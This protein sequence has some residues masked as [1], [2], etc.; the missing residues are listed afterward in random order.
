M[1]KITP[2]ILL[3]LLLLVS[4]GVSVAQ[5]DSTASQFNSNVTIFYVTCE[6]QGVVNLTGTMEPNFDVYYQLFSGAGGTGTALTGLRQVSVDGTYA[7]SEVTAYTGGTVPAGSTGSIKVY[8]A[9]ETTP[10]TPSGDTFTVDDIQDG[11]NNPQNAVTTSSDAGAGSTSSSSTSGGIRIRSP[12]GGY[13]NSSV[14]VTPEPPVVIGARQFVNPERS[15]TP[16]IIFAECDNFL[17]AA[18]PG[19]VYDNDN[20]VI[21]WSWYAKTSAQVQDHLAK[22][23]YSVR[24][25]S[26]PLVD[27]GTSEIEQ[28]G[29]NYW[30]FFTANIGNLRPGQYGV[31]YKV[32]WS[33]EHFDGYKKFGPGTNTL[34]QSATCT[35]T[36]DRN[37][38]GANAVYN[39]IYSVR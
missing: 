29:G 23:Q 12:F 21:F 19:V 31:E 17:P 22:V 4:V 13:I 27:V 32:A 7:V 1:R 6:N 36:V 15:S 26:A 25:N 24:L 18:A 34:E 5:T 37:P 9:R 11:C 16:G 20:I 10:N 39:N 3:V 8:I 2:V 38:N 14:L 33:E 28:R 35:F 30:V